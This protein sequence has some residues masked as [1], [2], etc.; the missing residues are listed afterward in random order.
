[1]RLLAHLPP[2]STPIVST[3]VNLNWVYISRLL[4]VDSVAV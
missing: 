2:E 4:H 3:I 1:M